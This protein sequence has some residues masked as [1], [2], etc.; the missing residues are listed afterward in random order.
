MT[1]Y[2]NKKNK[3]DYQLIKEGKMKSGNIWVAC[4]IYANS[5]GETFVREKMDFFSKFSLISTLLFLFFCTPAITYGQIIPPQREPFSS[6]FDVNNRDLYWM[7]PQTAQ[8]TIMC[9]KFEIERLMEHIHILT[10]VKDG[11]MD[12]MKIKILSCMSYR[13]NRKC[14]KC[15]MKLAE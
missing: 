8:D 10:D 3:Q 12:L 14:R 15:L 9:Q 13:N 11:Q 7:P 2:K 5:A 4:I 1:K 6:V